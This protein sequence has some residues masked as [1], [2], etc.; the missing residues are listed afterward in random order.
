MNVKIAAT[1]KDMLEV[2]P[3][4]QKEKGWKKF[5]GEFDKKKHIENRKKAMSAFK[6]KQSEQVLELKAY[7][8]TIL[9]DGLFSKIRRNDE[10]EP[11][12]MSHDDW[13]S[14][15]IDAAIQLA[16]K[17]MTCFS[18]TDDGKSLR[19][20]LRAEADKKGAPRMRR[21]KGSAPAIVLFAFL[22]FL[23][24]ERQLPTKKELN[25]ESNRLRKC[26]E[27]GEG[28]RAFGQRLA[29][30]GTDQIVYDS[31]VSDYGQDEKPVWRFRAV[32][33]DQWDV[34]Q[35]EQSSRLAEHTS[36]LGLKDLPEA[37]KDR[38]KRGR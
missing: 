21:D 10:G 30:N 14:R 7:C 8:D 12:F 11:D 27:L 18:E 38:G 20:A 28:E 9:R 16:Q 29:Y 5:A 31:F 35:W 3:H 24:R 17:V 19:N 23:H 33:V 32:P 6:P 13:T 26:Q 34:K 37:K 2:Y 4:L 22:K 25:I 36:P 1:S 15:R